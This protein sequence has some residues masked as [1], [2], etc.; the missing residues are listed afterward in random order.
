MYLIII[1]LFFLKKKQFYWK[2]LAKRL[3][4][5]LSFSLEVEES[6]INRLRV[7]IHFL[8][9]QNHFKDTNFDPILISLHVVMNLQIN[10]I[11][12]LPI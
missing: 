9:Y 12:C 10:F 4:N 5:S 11:V 6:M 8:F 7:G 1:L 2:N 3:I